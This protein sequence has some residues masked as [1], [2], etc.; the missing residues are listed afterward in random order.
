MIPIR[1][2]VWGNVCPVCQVQFHS[3]LRLVQHVAYEGHACRVSF[4]ESESLELPVDF[5]KQLDAIDAR[6][7]RASK[8]AGFPER[9][10]VVP[11]L[12]SLPAP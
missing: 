12:F 3:R 8:R 7:S 2:M 6:Q 9:H 5:I 10:T 4:L 1:R 11:A